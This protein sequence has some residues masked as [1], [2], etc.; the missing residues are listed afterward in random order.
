MSLEVEFLEVKRKDME[1]LMD[2]LKNLKKQIDM[3][4]ELVSHV[5]SVIFVDIPLTIN[6]SKVTVNWL[7][8]DRYQR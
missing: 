1:Y 8:R 5:R 2:H 7:N 3:E 4:C 6:R